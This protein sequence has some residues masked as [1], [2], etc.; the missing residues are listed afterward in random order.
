MNNPKRYLSTGI[1]YLLRF[2]TG[3]FVFTGLY[4]FTAGICSCI[5]VNSDFHNEENGIEI[6]AISNGVHTDITVPVKN[7]TADWSQLLPCSATISGTAFAREIPARCKTSRQL[8][9]A[10]MMHSTKPAERTTSF[11]PAMTGRAKD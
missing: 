5:P 1:R 9:M 6:A 3:F 4:L 10:G 7:E 11:R 2:V 8:A